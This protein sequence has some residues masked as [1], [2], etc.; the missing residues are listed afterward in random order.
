MRH[1]VGGH[2]K[3]SANRTPSVLG[4]VDHLLRMLHPETDCKRLGLHR[5]PKVFYHLKSIP[6]GMPRRKDTVFCLKKLF[7]VYPKALQLSLFHRKAGD[8]TVKPELSSKTNDLFS[9]TAYNE[10]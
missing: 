3:G 8:L 1:L 2:G 9:H 4:D 7:S 5:G 10:R 6:G